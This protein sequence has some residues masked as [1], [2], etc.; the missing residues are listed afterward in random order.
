MGEAE[1]FVL[2]FACPF[3]MRRHTRSLRPCALYPALF[4]EMGGIST[5]GRKEMRIKQG[6]KS[7][8]ESRA[9]LR[10]LREWHNL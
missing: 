7:T 8:P 2:E 4:L 6:N 1:G 9:I 10:I 5:G 3:Y